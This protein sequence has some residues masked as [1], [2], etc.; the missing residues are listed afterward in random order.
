CSCWR[1]PRAGPG[2]CSWGRC[3]RSPAC[4]HTGTPSRDA[5][6][7]RCC[8]DARRSSGSC[9]ASPEPDALLLPPACSEPGK[10][11]GCRPQPPHEI[12]HPG[13]PV[14]VLRPSVLAPEGHQEENQ[15]P[16]EAQA[17]DEDEQARD[18]SPQGLDPVEEDQLLGL[19]GWPQCHG[20][21]GAAPGRVPGH[22]H[23]SSRFASTTTVPSTGRLTNL[24]A[25]LLYSK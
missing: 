8:S 20:C 16:Q 21:L 15:E 25:W 5:S 4:S 13:E 17:C 24:L 18:P 2:P 23:G 3:G 22:Q 7:L 14:S 19:L 6:R 1:P 9:A 10:Q 11:P 12:E